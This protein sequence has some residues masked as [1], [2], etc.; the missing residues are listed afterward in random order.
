MKRSYL[1]A[2]SH[3][4]RSQ[5]E[6]SRNIILCYNITYIIFFYYKCS[7]T[8]NLSNAHSNVV[9]W[10]GATR[11]ADL[12]LI[13]RYCWNGHKRYPVVHKNQSTVTLS[14]HFNG[15]LPCN[16]YCQWHDTS[17]Y[18]WKCF[19][20]MFLCILLKAS[21]VV[22]FV[23]KI[24]KNL[25]ETFQLLNQAYREDCMNWTQWNDWSKQVGQWRFQAEHNFPHQQMTTT[26]REFKL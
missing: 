2:D 5:T 6:V 24:G 23:F 11:F 9:P 3:W 17:V 26:P 15:R 10:L 22:K 7:I 16:R 13:C 21:Y 25:I 19:K 8:M 18:E 1:V 14:S 4:T 20:T 12:S